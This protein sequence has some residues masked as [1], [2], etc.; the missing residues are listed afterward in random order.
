MRSICQL[1]SLLSHTMCDSANALRGRTDVARRRRAFEHAGCG[2]QAHSAVPDS[3]PWPLKSATS[4]TPSAGPRRRDPRAPALIAHDWMVTW[5]E[6]DA[7]ID[8]VAAGLQ[9]LDLSVVREPARVASRCR[10]CPS[11]RWRSS[12]CSAPVWSPSRSIPGYTARELRHCS[13]TP[14]RPRSSP[15]RRSLT[16]C[17]RYGPSS[18]HLRH[19]YAVGGHGIDGAPPFALLAEP[20]G[21][22]GRA[23]VDRRPGARTW[24]SCCTPRARPARPRARC[25]P[26]G[27]SS[28]TTARSSGFGRRS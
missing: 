5:G 25:S 19:T 27:R 3:A 2:R 28:P 10:T 26:T 1:L 12:P 23:T 11:S 7:R 9:A 15:R 8:A 14:A 22:G 4:P 6:L 20:T 13:T 18:R 21:E 24:P 16:P 17:R